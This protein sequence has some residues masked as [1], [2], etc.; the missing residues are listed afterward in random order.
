MLKQQPPS[1]EETMVVHNN[2]ATVEGRDDGHRRSTPRSYYNNAN[3]NRNK[4]NTVVVPH[5]HHGR[6]TEGA[7]RRR[8]SEYNTTY[9]TVVLKPPAYW[10]G[11][12]ATSPNRIT[13]YEGR[14]QSHR[15]GNG[16]IRATP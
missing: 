11:C 3:I 5:P 4:T 12:V 13:R 16:T 6:I 10:Q 9:S 15:R 8:R 7:K 2:K 14:T 1:K